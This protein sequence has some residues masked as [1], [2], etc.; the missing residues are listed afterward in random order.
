MYR[1]RPYRRA[2]SAWIAA[3]CIVFTLVTTSVE[4]GHAC[5]LGLH[6]GAPQI[7]T[8]TAD[9]PIHPAACL[10]CLGLHSP[11]LA[12]PIA[13]MLPQIVT[14]ATAP[15]TAPAH[16][17]LLEIFALQVRPPPGS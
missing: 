7:D 15:V 5:D 16:R 3:L 11:G 10:L 6:G 12:A 17:P 13:P 9:G 2:L 4:A 1:D 8:R 14:A